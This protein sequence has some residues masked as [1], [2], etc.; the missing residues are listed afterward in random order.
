MKQ[1][2]LIG[3]IA[4]LTV[5]AIAGWV[6][7]PGVDTAAAYPAQSADRTD[8]Y[9]QPLYS[10]PQSG[11]QQPYAAAQYPAQPSYQTDSFRQP[12]NTQSQSY[13]QQPYAAPQYT[14]QAYPAQAYAPAPYATTALYQR[15]VRYCR[16]SVLRNVYRTAYADRYYTERRAAVRRPRPFRH[17]LAIV[18]GS[19]GAGA[20][21]GA[22]AG[23]GKGA[24]IGALAGG[25]AGLIYDRFT[26]NR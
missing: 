17:S 8:A 13:A 1:G 26:H 3:G 2:I 5:A 22:L 23:G 11:P 14:A 25:A 4:M 15:P 18:G 24:G 20:A 21:I 12:S 10:R 9:G 6:R 19:A 16:R 7:K